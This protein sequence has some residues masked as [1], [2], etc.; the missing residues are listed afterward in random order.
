MS[1]IGKTRTAIGT[2]IR[3]VN[4][5]TAWRITVLIL[6]LLVL[7]GVIEINRLVDEINSQI[8]DLESSVE[9]AKESA[10]SAKDAAE[11]AERTVRFR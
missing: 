5:V 4:W 2:A 10:E 9:E 7:N 1:L 6:L 3:R 11:S 8:S